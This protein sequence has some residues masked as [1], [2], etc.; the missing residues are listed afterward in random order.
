MS[1]L[2]IKTKENHNREANIFYGKWQENKPDWDKSKA[3]KSLNFYLKKGIIK[4]EQE[5][6]HLSK[7]HINKV[8]S[9]L[10]FINSLLKEGRFYDWAIVGCYYAIYHSALSLLSIKGYSS[11][12]HLA[13]LCS[14]IYFYYSPLNKSKL[15]KEDI[16]LIVKSSIEKQEVSYF[17][18][19]KEKR[20][21][22]SYGLQKYNKQE[23]EDLREN[24]ILFINKVKMILDRI[25]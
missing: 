25:N 3:G 2:Q 11:K 1:L 4:K 10:D 19:A 13:T 16:K 9:N 6:E 24:T 15:N 8:D 21:T 23:A 18:D 5:K 7:S 22:A 14:L 12:N 17:V 20:E